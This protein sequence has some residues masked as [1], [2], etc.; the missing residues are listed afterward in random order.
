MIRNLGHHKQDNENCRT[1][2]FPTKRCPPTP[3]DINQV[4][5]IVSL[6]PRVHLFFSLKTYFLVLNLRP[7]IPSSG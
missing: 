6:S 4:H 7:G 2:L 5:L 1:G 3:A